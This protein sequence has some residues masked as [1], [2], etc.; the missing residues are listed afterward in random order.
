[1][2]LLL[3]FRRLEFDSLMG[4]LFSSYSLVILAYG[5]N[6]GW[7]RGHYGWTA[8]ASPTNTSQVGATARACDHPCCPARDRD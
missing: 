6:W 7:P 2:A 3:D 5:L 1:M 4:H 8:A